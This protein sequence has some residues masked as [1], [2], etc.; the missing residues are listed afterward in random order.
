MLGRRPVRNGSRRA[1]PLALAFLLLLAGLRAEGSVLQAQARRSLSADR[2]S[3][4]SGL[5]LYSRD[6]SPQER[7]ALSPD[8]PAGVL[9]TG[10]VAGGPAEAA[11]V[12]AGQRVVRV[13]GRLVEND[14]AFSVA[15]AGRA[16]GGEVRLESRDGNG[17]ATVTVKTAERLSYL[18]PAC[19]A[20]D[21]RACWDIVAV[22]GW[23]VAPPPGAD[24]PAPSRQHA[25]DLGSPEACTQIGWRLVTAPGGPQDRTRGVQLLGHS[26][27]DGDREACRV[28]GAAYFKGSRGVAASRPRALHFYDKGCNAG[29]ISSCLAAAQMLDTGGAVQAD[30]ATAR[31]AYEEACLRGSAPGCHRLGL[32]W[33]DGR[34]GPQDSAW[35]SVWLQQACESDIPEACID[36]ALVL[37]RISAA[38][39]Q[40]GLRLQREQCTSSRSEECSFQ[41]YSIGGSHAPMDMDRSA[42]MCNPERQPT[43]SKRHDICFNLGFAHELG[44]DVER[45]GDDALASAVGVCEQGNMLGCTRAGELLAEGREVPADLP[46]ALLLLRL[47][48]DGN[49][50][51]GCAALKRFGG[52]APDCR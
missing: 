18:A 10:V 40:R 46:R 35:A 31:V 12:R 36:L 13:D 14:K 52:G 7:A 20:G 49:E 32:F 9:I 38:D 33:R 43:V 25:C 48:C 21:G 28:L 4:T 16:V 11:S 8:D 26:C 17:G 3:G 6:L 15:L 50:P 39:A 30:L 2:P 45:R 47:A 23:R 42:R 29:G 22:Y 24:G 44:S 5:G 37:S 51:M 1:R 41:G 19:D 27:D 34:G